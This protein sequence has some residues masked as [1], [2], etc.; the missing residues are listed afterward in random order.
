MFKSSKLIISVLG[1]S[2]LFS[3]VSLADT[4]EV[5][6]TNAT[7]GQV[8]TPPL[9]FTHNSNV[10]LF[11]L[12][13]AAPSFLIPLAE[14]GD[15]SGFTGADSLADISALYMGT[16]GITPGSSQTF[17]IDTTSDHP[18]IT[19][20]AM[21]ASSNDAFISVYDQQLDF[22][23]ASK[24]YPAT[25]YDAGSER[26]SEDC[27]YIPGPP[28]GNGGVHDTTGAEGFVHVHNGIHGISSLN[29]QTYS[30]KNPG[31]VITIKH[32]Q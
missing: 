7:A 3:G 14:D 29:V 20:A 9:A 25:V 8:I 4:F 30:W 27:Q 1:A 12:G 23:F 22:G 31:A 10:S 5:T 18:L 2:V 11:K 28:C 16:G 13:Q 26:N 17:S 6:I 19:V 32:M 24:T 21:F 15:I